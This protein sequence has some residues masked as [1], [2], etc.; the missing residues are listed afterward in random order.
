MTV[1]VEHELPMILSEVEVVGVER[2]SP[3]FVRLELGG[4]ALADFG[5]AGPL[6]D[7]RIKIV[8]PGAG[9]TLPTLSAGPGWYADWLALPEQQRGSMRTYTVREVRGSG[10]GTRIVVDVVLHLAPGRSG[11]GS[12]WAASAR[13]GDRVV[14]TAPRRGFEYGGIEFAPGG[15]RE[16]LL[17]ADETAVPAVGGI[18]RDLGPEAHGA[19]FLE[20]P[21]AGDIL[22]LDAPAGMQL[23]WLPREG[24]PHGVRQVDAVRR[25]LDLPPVTELVDDRLVDPDLWETPTYSSRGEELAGTAATVATAAL[26]DLYAWIAGE[27]KVV[28]TLRR[29]MVTELGLHRSQVAFMGYWREGVAMKG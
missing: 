17:V 2:I 10:A 13:P 11:P 19:V 16:L 18:L 26:P 7:Q 14:M 15:A 1:D 12:T 27:S 5:V 6:Y 29:C 9:G 22:D 23:T 3:S 28:T 24:A 20:V 4:A 8:L 21:H 25:Y